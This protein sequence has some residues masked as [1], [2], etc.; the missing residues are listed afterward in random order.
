MKYKFTLNTN[1][2]AVVIDGEAKLFDKT[3]AKFLPLRDACL[4]EDDK[5]ID[6]L[7]NTEFKKAI[8][9]IGFAVKDDLV[10]VDDE[11]LPSYLGRRLKDL[12]DA[13]K[14]Y[15]IVLKFWHKL[16]NN[17]SHHSVEQLPSFINSQHC[18]LTPDGNFIGYKA[19]THDWKDKY[20]RKED[21]SIGAEPKMSRRLVDDDF[22]LDCSSGYHIGNF[23]YA[24]NFAQGDDRLV[25]CEVNPEHVVSVA[26]D[27]GFGKLRVCTYKVIREITR[28]GEM[29]TNQ[30]YGEDDNNE[31]DKSNNDLMECGC[32][33]GECDCE[34]YDDYDEDDYDDEEDH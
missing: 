23:S 8:E 7:L 3:D 10:F 1:T 25:E 34:L 6:E 33:I 22:S 16:K 20:T 30:V 18:P 29:P 27:S 17:P 15:D 26:P 12:A 21:N 14:P 2:L 31:D 5:K 32:P 11:C 24:T 28:G 13:G 19:I 9:Y 4:A